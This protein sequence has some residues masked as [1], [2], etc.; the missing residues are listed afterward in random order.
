ML[1]HARHV[2]LQPSP[3]DASE[4]AKAIEEV[5]SD[6]LAHFDVERFWPAHPLEEGLADGNTSFYFGATGMIWALEYLRAQNRRPGSDQLTRQSNQAAALILNSDRNAQE[7]LDSGFLEKSYQNA[8]LPKLGSE[9]RA[10]AAGM[11]RGYQ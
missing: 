2:A 9:V 4:V 1:E 11:A 10:A 7:V 6:A 3:W 8:V 5:V